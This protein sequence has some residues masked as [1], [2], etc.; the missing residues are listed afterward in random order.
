LHTIHQLKLF[1]KNASCSANLLIPIHFSGAKVMNIQRYTLPQVIQSH[2]NPMATMVAFSDR[3]NQISVFVDD[4][5]GQRLLN[6][7]NLITRKIQKPEGM[8]SLITHIKANLK[9]RGYL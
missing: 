9:E 7:E 2:L 6:I 1:V 8:Q 4:K 3:N 5:K